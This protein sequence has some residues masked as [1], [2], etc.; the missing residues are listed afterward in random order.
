MHTKLFISALLITLSTQVLATGPTQIPF[1]LV[2]K[3]ILV[4]AT[5]NGIEGNFILD[6]GIRNIVLNSKYF[7]GSPIDRQFHGINGEVGEMQ[8]GYFQLK[9]AALQWK[10]VYAEIIPLQHLERLK[11]QRIHGLIGGHLF[12][13][14]A[15]WLN[16]SGQEMWLEKA[17]RNWATEFFSTDRPALIEAQ[18]FKY[19][20]GS[21]CI[22]LNVGGSPY[23][24]S[25]DTGAETNILDTRFKMTLSPYYNIDSQTVLYSFRKEASQASYTRLYSLQ[26]GALGCQPMRTS[27]LNLSNWNRVTA[28]P[29][30]DGILGYEFL[31]QFKVCIHFKKRMIYFIPNED[32]HSREI[33]TTRK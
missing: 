14:Y 13:N 7:K 5:I 27:F 20:G 16:Y 17:P 23:T 33:F 8:A 22:S 12:R 21:P 10:G 32:G 6:T 31:H 26:L 3:M 9:M 18:Q 25:L 15:L 2:G 11:G 28:G 29:T 24:F 4:E 1:K 30:V 19:K